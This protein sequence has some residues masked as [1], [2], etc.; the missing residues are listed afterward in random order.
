MLLKAEHLKAALMSYFRFERLWIVA[1]EVNYGSIG[2]IA[3]ILVDTGTEI[4]EVETKIDKSDLLSHELKKQKHSYLQD[5]ETYKQV[6][7]N[8][9]YLCV[10]LSLHRIALKFIEETNTRY[11]LILFDTRT[12]KINSR[13]VRIVKHPKTL[14]DYY[15]KDI[16][17]SIVMRLCS[18]IANIYEKK[19][20]RLLKKNTLDEGTSTGDYQE[21]LDESMSPEETIFLEN[22]T[23]T[24]VPKKRE[25]KVRE[26]KVR[27]KKERLIRVRED[28]T[29]G[30]DI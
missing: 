22:E 12:S 26:V 17:E 4:I 18:E 27:V 3:D 8:K 23:N 2:G 21:N 30:I 7:P 25:V 11:G 29:E 5:P 13:S 10:P 19:A 9:Y 24:R 1:T 14:H 15:N 16:A 20:N 28:I 6:L